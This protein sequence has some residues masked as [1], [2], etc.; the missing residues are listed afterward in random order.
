MIL[1]YIRTCSSLS[2]ALTLRSRDSNL[3]PQTNP[4]M[5]KRSSIVPTG[6]S[7]L[8]VCSKVSTGSSNLAV[9]SKVS[10]GS[11]P[12]HSRV[13]AELLASIFDLA[14]LCRDLNVVRVGDG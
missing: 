8:G 14:V 7:N 1:K 4:L 13:H 5:F 11:A 10:T 9:C 6:S 12:P 2:L 3:I